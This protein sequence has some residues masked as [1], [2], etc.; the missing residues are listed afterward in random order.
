MTIFVLFALCSCKEQNEIEMP[1]LDKLYI[2]EC[3][4]ALLEEYEEPCLKFYVAGFCE[5]DKNFN[6]K[7]ARQLFYNSYYYYNSEDIVPDSLRN[8]ISNTLLKY[9]TDTTFLYQGE[10]GSRI[11]DGNAYRFIMQKCNQKDIIIK[12]EPK[13]LPEDLKFVYSFLYEN[14]EKTEHKSKY[15]ELFEMFENQIKNDTSNIPHPP[16]LK[17]TIKFTRPVIKGK[18]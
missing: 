3:N 16:R 2:L 4:Y 13:F 5:L 15:N 8:K 9:Q 17:S 1:P 18:K 12:F 10:P 7:Y 11:Y 14:R 6:V